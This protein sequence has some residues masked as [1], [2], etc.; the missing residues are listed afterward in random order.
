METGWYNR[1]YS[2]CA[3]TGKSRPVAIHRFIPCNIYKLSTGYPHIGVHEIFMIHAI[4][5]T[6]PSMDGS[7]TWDNNSSKYVNDI[8]YIH[9]GFDLKKINFAPIQNRRA[10]QYDVAR[11]QFEAGRKLKDVPN[12]TFMTAAAAGDKSAQGAIME[13]GMYERAQQLK[14]KKE[15]NIVDQLRKQV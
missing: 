1:G 2:Y 11:K 9:M 15:K 14:A 13:K 6:Y 3:K 12:S 8:K 5:M 4:L 10:A 7:T